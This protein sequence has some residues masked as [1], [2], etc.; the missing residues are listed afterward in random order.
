[1][2]ERERFIVAFP[3]GYRRSWADARG[4][5][6]AS[7]AGYDD[8]AFLGALVSAF[9]KDHHADPARVYFTG[10]SNGGFMTATVACALADRVAAIAMVGATVPEGFDAKCKPSRPM[11]A[12]LVLGDRDPLVPY[13]GGQVAGRGGENNRAA[14]GEDSARFWATANGCAPTP[15]ISSLPD[16]DPDDGTRTTLRKWESC[17]DGADVWLYTVEGGGHTWPGGW[18]YFGPRIIGKT[19]RDFDATD[20]IWSFFKAKHR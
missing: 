5:T 2:A 11:P 1:V 8:V 3:D 15:A 20:A 12:M 17:K 18:Q 9:V 16:T 19:A 7:E 14:S 13:A 4:A 6:P 10:M